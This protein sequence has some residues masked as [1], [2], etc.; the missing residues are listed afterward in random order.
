MSTLIDLGC[1]VADAHHRYQEIH[2]ALFGA[3]SFRLIIDA[4]RGRRRAAY[5]AYAQTLNVLQDELTELGG[6]ISGLGPV[7]PAKSADRELQ[8]VLLEYTEVLEEAVTQLENI[9]RNLE[10]DESAYRDASID[11]RSQFTRDKLRYDHLLL[12]LERLGTQ[13]N[14]LFSAY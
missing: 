13:L 9:F 14:R 4:L 12:G 7:K 6:K 5:S 3:G 8:Q 10:Q 2:G 1:K 11:G